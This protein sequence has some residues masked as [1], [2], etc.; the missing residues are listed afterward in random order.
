MWKIPQ[1]HFSKDKIIDRVTKI[2][3]IFKKI[4]VENKVN[5]INVKK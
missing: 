3:E 5:E 1:I 2:D 4:N